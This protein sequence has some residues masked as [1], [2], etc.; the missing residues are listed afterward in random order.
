MTVPS[1]ISLRKQTVDVLRRARSAPVGSGDRHDLWQLA[2]G[3]RWLAK[4]ATSDVEDR[5]MNSKNAPRQ[6]TL[7]SKSTA[8]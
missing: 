8:A 3:L 1:A 6:N 2:S 5:S 7:I 4:R